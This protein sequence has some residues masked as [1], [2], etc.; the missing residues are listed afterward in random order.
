LENP[1][2]HVLGAVVSLAELIRVA[3]LVSMALLVTSLGMR[4]APGD[5][6]YL[7]RRPRLLLR[8]VLA[9]NIIM[10]IVVIWLVVT[11]DLRPAVKVALVALSVSPVPPFLPNKQLKLTGRQGYVYGLLV[12]SA[13]LALVL[14]PLMTA[15]LQHFA[16]QR[17]H[18][19]PIERVPVAVVAKIVITTVLLPLALGLILRHYSGE[20]AERT[21]SILAKIGGVLLIVA[22][23]PVLLSQWPAIRSLL[24]DGTLLV[25]VAFTALGLCIGHVFGGTDPE[26]RTVLALATASRHPAIAMA[27]ASAV[28]PDQK[29]AP[30]AVLL[31]LLVGT[32][33]STPYSSWRSKVRSQTAHPK[34]SPV[35]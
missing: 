23:V 30:A 22:F 7:F 21:A 8:S 35:A 32:L 3:I 2:E 28:F 12:A 25:I 20:R 34:E 6:G 11:L 27:V 31:A 18:I 17:E 33:A 29:L 13:V 10:P 26:D 24:G 19:A 1:H 15:L 9:M 14:V 16:M 4:A 5:A